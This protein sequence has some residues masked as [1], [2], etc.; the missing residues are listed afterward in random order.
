MGG[1][2]KSRRLGYQKSDSEES[3]N[4]DRSL[5]LHARSRNHSEEDSSNSGRHESYQNKKHESST[6]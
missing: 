4:D 3:K 6:S 2:P 5:S 1:G